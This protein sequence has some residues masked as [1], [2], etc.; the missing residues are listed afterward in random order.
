MTTLNTLVSR[1]IHTYSLCRN[2]REIQM[3]FLTNCYDRQPDG[4]HKWTLSRK[5]TSKLAN[6]AC[7]ES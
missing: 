3:F 4:K 2:D 6:K 5:Y 7:S 1:E